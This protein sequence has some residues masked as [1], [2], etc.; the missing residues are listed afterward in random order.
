MG[1]LGVPGTHRWGSSSGVDTDLTHEEQFAPRSAAGQCKATIQS[2]APACLIHPCPYSFL[3]LHKAL[4]SAFGGTEPFSKAET[5]PSI[6]FL[7]TE[8]GLP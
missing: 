3:P 6:G 4:P 8:K 5:S 2:G 1:D 7:A